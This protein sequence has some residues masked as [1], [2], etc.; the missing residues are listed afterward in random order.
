MTQRRDNSDTRDTEVVSS[1]SCATALDTGHKDSPRPN[2]NPSSLHADRKDNGTWR[3]HTTHVELTSESEV[4]IH[5]ENCWIFLQRQKRL[6]QDMYPLSNQANRTLVVIEES[7]G[8]PLA[9]CLERRQQHQ[10]LERRLR[11][12]GRRRAFSHSERDTPQRPIHRNTPTVQTTQY[13]TQ[14]H[15]VTLSRLPSFLLTV[16]LLARNGEERDLRVTSVPTPLCTVVSQAELLQQSPGVAVSPS[17]S[18]ARPSLTN[19]CFF[20]GCAQL[21]HDDVLSARCVRLPRS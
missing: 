19:S 5:V 1:T 3:C 12:V 21:P 15:A 20:S 2:N 6:A 8:T 14:P 16:T 7:L 10:C 13:T 18:C 9:W 4:H 11:V 17:R